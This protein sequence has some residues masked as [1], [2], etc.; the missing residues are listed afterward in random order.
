MAPP[1]GSA[2]RRY[3]VANNL[4]F[5]S[6]SIKELISVSLKRLGSRPCAALYSSVYQEA[7]LSNRCRIIG[8]CYVPFVV[9][10]SFSRR[11]A[12]RF[13]Q[14][15]YYHHCLPFYHISWHFET[16]SLETVPSNKPV[17]TIFNA[18]FQNLKNSFRSSYPKIIY[19]MKSLVTFSFTA[20]RKIRLQ[21]YSV[22]PVLNRKYIKN[23]IFHV[24]SCT[25]WQ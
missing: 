3:V 22:S 9:I 8:Y 7:P 17:I 19:A 21:C 15:Y 6:K 18:C 1:P 25:Y 24:A 14:R 2:R 12:R 13:L 10:N 5:S 20:F 4:H 11:L 23:W 16:S